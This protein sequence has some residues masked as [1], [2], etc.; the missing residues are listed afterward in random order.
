MPR[1]CGGA[2]LGATGQRPV[3][4]QAASGLARGAVVRL[5]ACVADP[6][7]RLATRRARLTILPV[8]RHLLAKRGDLLWPVAPRLVDQSL[9]PYTQ[10]PQRRGVQ[11]GDVGIGH[12][13]RLQVERQLSVKQDLVRV[14]VA[15]SCEDPG[16]GQ[17]SFDRMVARTQASVERG[18][19]VGHLE[20]SRVMRRQLALAANQMQRG[21]TLL[22]RLGQKQRTGLEPPRGERGLRVRLCR[23]LP[24]K[25]P[26]DHQVH[27][28]EPVVVERQHD[29]LSE[30]SGA[31]EPGVREVRGRRLDRPEQER[32]AHLARE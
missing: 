12:L 3:G 20:A 11:G 27:D 5:V 15:D 10:P 17:R 13:L 8:D 29:A 2:W 6:L 14:C 30:P 28:R 26:G 23:G 18:E 22:A 19:V 31:S 4:K 25:A 16:V 9:R 24:P 32:V 7:H 21:A 1:A